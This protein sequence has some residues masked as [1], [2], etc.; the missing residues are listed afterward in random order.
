MDP[1]AAIAAYYA[2]P[3][4]IDTSHCALGGTLLDSIAAN[5]GRLAH[6]QASDTRVHSPV[7]QGGGSRASA[8][9]PSGDRSASGDR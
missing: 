6:V 5:A 8:F 9:T 3:A 2:N 4:C 7:A 1:A